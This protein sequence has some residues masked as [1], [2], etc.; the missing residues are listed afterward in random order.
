MGKVLFEMGILFFI[1][2]GVIGMLTLWY[3]GFEND[4]LICKTIFIIACI[5]IPIIL[6][7]TGLMIGVPGINI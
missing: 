7:I 4:N 2:T 5:L 6:I 1:V 3:Y